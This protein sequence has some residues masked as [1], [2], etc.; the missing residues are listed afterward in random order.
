MSRNKTNLRHVDSQ[1]E[2][3]RVTKDEEG[4]FFIGN[5]EERA[6]GKMCHY[7]QINHSD[8]TG[9][10]GNPFK[11]SGNGEWDHYA[12]SADDL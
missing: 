7:S 4:N 9:T 11:G 10:Y 12:H 5:T 2:V 3:T 1:G 6:E 8:N